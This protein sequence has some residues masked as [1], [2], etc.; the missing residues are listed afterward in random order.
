VH[1]WQV[2]PPKPQ[3][4]VVVPALQ[5]VLPL[6]QQPE[7]QFWEQAGVAHWPFWQT[8]LPVQPQSI[9]QV[10]QFSPQPGAQ[11]PSPQVQG[12]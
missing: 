3:A 7:G 12:D 8:S 5:V 2:L 4:E 1:V 10:E 11:V 6:G 9:S